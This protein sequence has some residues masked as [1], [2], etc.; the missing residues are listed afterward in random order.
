MH[1]PPYGAPPREI[2]IV[3]DG[4]RPRDWPVGENW[5]AFY[6][7]FVDD[8]STH[9]WPK[10]D[11]SADDRAPRIIGLVRQLTDKRRFD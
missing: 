10:W 6:G 7:A 4:A 8:V 2:G 11:P 3:D 9:I 5:E 1:L